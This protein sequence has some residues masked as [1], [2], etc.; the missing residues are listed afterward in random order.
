LNNKSP[1]N[2][3]KS[4]LNKPGDAKDLNKSKI[5]HRDKSFLDISDFN[6]DE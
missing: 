3:I 2:T 5:E 6:I 4:P 1:S